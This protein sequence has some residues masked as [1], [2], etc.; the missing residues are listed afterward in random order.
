MNPRQDSTVRMIPIDQIT[1]LNP[2]QR[3]KKK[4]QGIVANIGQLGLKKP[5]TVALDANGNGQPRYSLACGQ[6]RLEAYQALGQTE[7]PAIVIEAPKEDLLL[8]SLVENLARRQHTTVE[9]AK[10]IG[11]LKERGYSCADIA[12][13]T[14]LDATYINGIVK[15]LNKGEERLLQAVEKRKIPLSVAV[16]IATSSDKSVQRAMAEAYEKKE[17]RGRALLAAR[18]LIEQRRS[19]GKG[20]RRGV[21]SRAEGKVSSKNLLKAYKEETARQRALVK[22]AKLCETKLL[23]AVSA[24]KQIFQDDNF[25]TLLRAES[26]DS[27]PHYLAIQIHGEGR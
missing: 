10:E 1:V 17:L 19:L 4:F 3:G 6:G 12:Q 16:T 7:I 14:G 18:R 11:S 5:I 20:L 15:L 22:K 25:V 24:L 27:L 21:R 23:F 8:M 2:R 9:L 26:L 13:K